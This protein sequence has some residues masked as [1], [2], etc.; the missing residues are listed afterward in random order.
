M[1]VVSVSLF[2]T[3]RRER[4]AYQP[5]PWIPEILEGM[6]GCWPDEA[7]SPAADLLRPQRISQRAE[8]PRLGETTGADRM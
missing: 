1:A 5:W 6:C 3:N 7:R 2:P 8:A 4:A